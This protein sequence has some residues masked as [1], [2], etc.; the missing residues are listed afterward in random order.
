MRGWP[1]RNPVA[2]IEEVKKIA[3]EALDLAARHTKHFDTALVEE[4]EAKIAALREKLK[5]VTDFEK[6]GPFPDDSS[7]R[8]YE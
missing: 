8:R 1:L 6:D 7:E 3:E 5:D 4:R 2:V